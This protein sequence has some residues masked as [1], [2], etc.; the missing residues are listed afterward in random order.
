MI[1]LEKDGLR[2]E[3][4]TD[5]QASAFER[6][7]YKR[8]TAEPVPKKE[9]EPEQEPEKVEETPKRRRRRVASKAE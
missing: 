9:Q 3:V 7:G 2:M 6:N 1:I 8:V 4:C 5:V